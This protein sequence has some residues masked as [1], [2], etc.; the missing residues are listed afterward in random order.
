MKDEQEWQ[1]DLNWRHL[2]SRVATISIIVLPLIHR[3]RKDMCAF[4]FRFSTIIKAAFPN[5]KTLTIFKYTG[6]NERNKFSKSL[7]SNFLSRFVQFF[8]TT[9]KS[10][11]LQ[12]PWFLFVYRFSSTTPRRI[13]ADTRAHLPISFSIIMYTHTQHRTASENHPNQ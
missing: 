6:Y 4:F 3:W 10:A 8:N 5:K 12:L 1:L 13:L 2:L 11:A 9:K 7:L